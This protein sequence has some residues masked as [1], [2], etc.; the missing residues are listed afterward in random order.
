MRERVDI[1]Q[2]DHALGQQA[3]GPARIILGRSR[4]GQ[5]NQVCLLRAI[6][7][8]LVD[9][10]STPVGADRGGQPLLDKAL[11]HAF[12]GCRPG[13]NGFGDARVAPG[14]PTVGLI[15]LEQDLGVLDLA[16]VCL[17]AGQQPFKLLALGRDERH[18]VLLGHGRPPCSASPLTKERSDHH[19]S[20]DKAPVGHL[21][22][23]LAF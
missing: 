2:L 9:P 16:N 23:D 14:R 11:T 10:L 8:T 5:R 4:A 1:G 19:L 18:P 20:S 15:R 21:L 13:L 7:L 17:A 22:C 12:H 6:E 3:Q